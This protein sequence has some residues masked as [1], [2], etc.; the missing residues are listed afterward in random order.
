[1]IDLRTIVDALARLFNKIFYLIY[2]HFIV[3]LHLKCFNLKL[4]YF[5][6]FCHA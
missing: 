6:I 4:A 5:C 2:I 1:M 3:L